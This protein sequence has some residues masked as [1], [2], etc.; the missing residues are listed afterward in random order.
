[1]AKDFTHYVAH[2]YG[3]GDRIFYEQTF[4]NLD[5]LTFRKQTTRNGK[6]WKLQTIEIHG[7]RYKFNQNRAMRAAWTPLS[8]SCP[9]KPIS[10]KTPYKALV[11]LLHS[12]KV[13]I[14]YYQEPGPPVILEEKQPIEWNCPSCEFKSDSER[15]VKTHITTKH[16]TENGLKPQVEN[17][18]IVKRVITIPEPVEPM[19]ISRISQ[20]SG[21]MTE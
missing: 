14:L 5:F 18:K 10:W 16:K 20:P 11:E 21:R 4:R 8:R 15:G 19:H 9:F 6:E 7:H 13:G 12:K 3:A 17:W 2:V 1:M